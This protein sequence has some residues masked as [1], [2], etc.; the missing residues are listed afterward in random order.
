MSKSIMKG[1][2]MKMAN[3]ASD[4]SFCGFFFVHQ[5]FP[6]KDVRIQP[7]LLNEIVKP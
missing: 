6:A 7:P 5:R 1:K 3:S 2:A 4:F